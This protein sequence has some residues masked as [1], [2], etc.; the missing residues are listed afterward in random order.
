TEGMRFNTAISQM[1]IFVNEAT[2]SKTLPRETLLAFIRVLAAYA[3]HLAEEAWE[4]LGQKGF[5]SHAEWPRWDESLTVDN[6]VAMAVSVNGKKRAEIEVARDAS[7]A[8]VEKLALAQENVIRH[9]EGK[10]PKRV[11]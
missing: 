1:M 2:S 4:R 8:E 10:T 5:A 3:P 11:I 6:T 9:L 7:A